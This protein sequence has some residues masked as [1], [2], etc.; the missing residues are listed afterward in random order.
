MLRFYGHNVPCAVFARRPAL[1]KAIK[2]ENYSNRDNFL[3]RAECLPDQGVAPHPPAAAILAF[4]QAAEPP[5]GYFLRDFEG[6]M[7]Y[8]FYTGLHQALADIRLDPRG[9]LARAPRTTP[10]P[11]YQTWS[12]LSLDNRRVQ[13]ATLAAFNRAKTDVAA[14]YRRAGLRPADARRAADAGLRQLAF[15]LDCGGPAQ[16]PSLRRLLLDG[17]PLRQIKAFLAS[18]ALG[19]PKTTAAFQTCA[20]YAGIEP[21]SHI[22]IARSDALPLLWDAAQ[23]RPDLFANPDLDLNL[24]PNARNAFGK[25]PLMTAAQSGLPD[26]VRLLLARNTDPN[27]RTDPAGTGWASRTPL[28]YAAAS[29]SLPVIKM[30]LAAGADPQAA[31]SKGKRALHYLLGYGPVPPNPHLSTTALAEAAKLLY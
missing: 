18:P 27:A 13:A 17:A 23:R 3:P 9:L 26:A 29:G 25:T 16:R 12:Y 5:S 22:A 30:L 2:P 24:D 8:G 15:G 19:D 6:S 11:P 1:L 31:D 28:M 21:L 4:G 14:Y 10:E 7:Q 20:K